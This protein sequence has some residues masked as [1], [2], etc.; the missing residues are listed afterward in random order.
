[1]RAL[2]QDWSLTLDKIFDKAARWHGDR[3]VITRSVEGPIV[4]S[5]YAEVYARAKQVSH[6][7]REQRIGPGDRV[8]TMA[9]NSDRHLE[10]WYGA[11]GIGAVLQ[12]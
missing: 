5:T 8:A 6:G 1:M 7:L 12:P 9:W 2:M 11:V 4:R 3:E 10:V